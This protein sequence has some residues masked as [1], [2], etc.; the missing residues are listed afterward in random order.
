MAVRLQFGSGSSSCVG[1]RGTAR[2]PG[3][4]E[5]RLVIKKNFGKGNLTFLI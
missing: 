5:E 2:M 1:A 3:R 4:S